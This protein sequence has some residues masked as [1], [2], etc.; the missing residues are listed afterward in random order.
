VKH[1]K[2]RKCEGAC[3]SQGIC[4][5]D[6]KRVSVESSDGKKWGEWDYCKIAIEVDTL[7]NYTVEIIE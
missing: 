4:E 1:P 5:G 2:H 6:V 3:S 7:N